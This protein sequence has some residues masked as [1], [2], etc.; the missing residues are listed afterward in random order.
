MR[1]YA[2]QLEQRLMLAARVE[3]HRGWARRLWRAAL[4]SPDAWVAVVGTTGAAAAIVAALLLTAGAVP[5]AAQAFPILA[6]PA[7][8]VRIGLQ[9]LHHAHPFAESDGT[10]YVVESSDGSTLCVDSYPPPSLLPASTTLHDTVCETGIYAQEHGILESVY[11][12]GLPGDYRYVAL[13]PVGGSVDLTINGVTAPVAV[14]PDGIAT[15]LVNQDASVSLH[16]AGVT[17][18]ESLGPDAGNVTSLNVGS[19]T[20][21]SSTTTG[22]P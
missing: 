4:A 18:T 11:W 10:G 8:D 13:V 22:A 17:N 21:G 12:P 14:G 2:E 1:D 6:R 5:S 20:T 19:G 3:A 7:P 9:T 16:V 15:G